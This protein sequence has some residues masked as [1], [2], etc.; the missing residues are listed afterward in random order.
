MRVELLHQPAST[1]AKVTL[2]HGESIRAESGAMLA[3]T[4]TIELKS[5]IEGGLGKALGRL[6][7]RESL[8]QTTFT[9]AHGPGEVLLAPAGPGDVVVLEPRDGMM[10]TSGCFL[11][12]DPNLTFETIASVKNFFSGEGM[13]LMRV[14]GAGQLMLSSYGAIHPVQLQPGQQYLVDT[15]HLVA[16]SAGLGYRLRKAASGLLNT[17]KSGEGIVVE[18]T[19]PGIAYLQTRTPQLMGAVTSGAE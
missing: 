5:K 3:M 11:A 6:L 13:F 18:L 17:L 19:G 1:I 16:F 9:A 12:C 14:S 4:P 10:V 2:Q 15:G 7:S 8:F